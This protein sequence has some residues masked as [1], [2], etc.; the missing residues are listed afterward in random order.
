MKEITS[1]K[2]LEVVLSTLK[3]FHSPK[4][5]LEQYSTPSSIAAEILWKAHLNGHLEGKV[6]VD[7]GAGTG[8][9]GIGCLLLGA[10]KVYF[11]ESDLSAIEILKE[12]IK[13][14]ES[15]FSGLGEIKILHESIESFNVHVDT[16]LSNPPFCTREAHLDK[17]FVEKALS[18]AKFTYSFHKTST[19]NYIMKLGNVVERFDFNFLLPNTMKHHQKEKQYIKVS[20]LVFKQ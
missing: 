20:C 7:L 16:S 8:I 5:S 19:L 11:I 17:I 14:I 18:I 10:K 4:V 1:K 13:K 12:N 9:L 15:E 2:A 6:S 3:G